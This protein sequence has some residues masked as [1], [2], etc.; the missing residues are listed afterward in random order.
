MDISSYLIFSFRGQDYLSVPRDPI[1]LRRVGVELY[2]EISL[3]RWLFKA[4]IRLA[5]S[6]RLDGLVGREVPTPVPRYPNF[7]FRAWL[8]Q[9]RRDLGARDAVAVVSF[10]GQLRR[11][12]FYV[13]LLSPRGT[14]LAFAKVSLDAE[15]DRCLITEANALGYLASQSLWSFRVPKVLAEGKSHSHHYLILQALPA[16]ARAFSAK[17]GPIPQRCRDELIAASRHMK[18]IR[19]LSWWDRFRQRG[20][21][22]RVLARAIEADGVREAEVCWA[23]GDFT[24]RNICHADDEVWVFD[25]ENSAPDAPV[26]TDEVRFFL[27]MRGGQSSSNPIAL[28]TALGR[29]YLANGQE[30][31]RRNLALALA[32]LGT[33]TESGLICGRYW[34]KII[35]AGEG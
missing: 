11:A 16:A 30:G 29:R 9:A 28:A 14:P 13:N 24:H 35:R 26:M 2:K 8:E 15:S 12:R 32:F 23:H 34:N 6:L 19:E 27:G 25:W 7:E 31:Q 21:E 5:M 20:E 10:P 3:R 1:H 22:V 33:C 18:P 17:W 4:A